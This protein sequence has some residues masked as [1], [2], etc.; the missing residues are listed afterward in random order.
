[1]YLDKAYNSI[2]EEQKLIKQG[3]VLHITPKRKMGEEEEVQVTKQP[4]LNRKKYSATRLVNME[5]TNS[6]HIRVQKTVYLI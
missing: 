6:W 2:Q 3:Y 4:C 5:R 1:M